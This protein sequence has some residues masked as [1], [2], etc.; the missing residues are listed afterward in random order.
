VALITVLKKITVILLLGC[1]FTCTG[2]YWLV[3]Q[4]QQ[5][6]IKKEMRAK[7]KETLTESETEKFVFTLN[8]NVVT[9]ESFYWENDQEFHYQDKMYDVIE[10]K[11]LSN[12]L[13]ITCIN[14]YKEKQ[15]IN[16][17]NEIAKKQNEKPAKSF[18][19]FQLMPGLFFSQ[20]ST[21]SFDEPA[22]A[23]VPPVDGYKFS[24]HNHCKEI[25]TPPPQV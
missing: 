12:K 18:N 11:T 19:V 7:I 2:G 1:L 10:K 4:Y 22:A 14:D 23:N 6:G 20:F 5:Y 16:K 15:L 24:Y 9:E 25:T 21:F 13:Y 8:N 17:Y 3:A